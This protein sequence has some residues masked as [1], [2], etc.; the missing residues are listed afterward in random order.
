LRSIR[1]SSFIQCSCLLSFV[2]MGRILLCSHVPW[3]PR[4]FPTCLWSS[5]VPWLR[6]V[7]DWCVNWLC[8]CCGFIQRRCQVCVDFMFCAVL[9]LGQLPRYYKSW[10]F[11]YVREWIIVL[12]CTTRAFPAAFE[13]DL[14]D[15]ALPSHLDPGMTLSD[16]HH[17]TKL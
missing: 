8:G 12:S 5:G 9:R 15:N 2:H 13:P 3:R 17:N 6:T 14:S 10:I 1:G 11:M 7:V 16:Q 4:S